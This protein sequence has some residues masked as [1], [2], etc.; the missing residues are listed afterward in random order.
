MMK[1]L[2]PP[3]IMYK[4]P[5]SYKYLAVHD[6]RDTKSRTVTK[7]EPSY[8][9]PSAR[10]VMKQVFSSYQ[11]SCPVFANWNEIMGDFL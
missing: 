5:R 3:S 10:D 4:R 7:R 6:C 8:L 9:Y 1:P 2:T 11:A